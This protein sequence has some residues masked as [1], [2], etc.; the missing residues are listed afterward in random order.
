MTVFLETRSLPADIVAW[1]SSWMAND[2]PFDGISQG[3]CAYGITVTFRN[4]F[5]MDI[6]VMNGDGVES[7]WIACNLYEPISIDGI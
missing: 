7:S 6:D 5:Q 2:I 4:D 3:E 1:L